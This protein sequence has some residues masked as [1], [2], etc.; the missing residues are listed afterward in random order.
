MG[1]LI[2]NQYN[3]KRILIKLTR[4]KRE[5]VYMFQC[6]PK[7]KIHQ[8]VAIIIRGTDTINGNRYVL[9]LRFNQQNVMNEWQ[10]RLSQRIKENKELPQ[11]RVCRWRARASDWSVGMEQDGPWK[12]ELCLH[13]N[14]MD[15]AYCS[16]C[17]S[18][19]PKKEK[20]DEMNNKKQNVDL[21]IAAAD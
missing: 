15:R 5:K 21:E 11:S 9:A 10:Q 18:P 8:N 3:P 17:Y 12:C 19:K 7:H 2:E 6:K 4:R 16:I 20:D 14:G 13:A 1:E